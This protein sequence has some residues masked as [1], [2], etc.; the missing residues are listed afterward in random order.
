[1][2]S[3]SLSVYK[4]IKGFSEIAMGSVRREQNY[5]EAA[6]RNKCFVAQVSSTSSRPSLLLVDVR[7]NKDYGGE[8]WVVAIERRGGLLEIHRDG[9]L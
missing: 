8:L 4:Q 6:V 5:S 9:I 3:V 7:T 1:M 2:F